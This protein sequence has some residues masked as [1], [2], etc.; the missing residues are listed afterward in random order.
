MRPLTFVTASRTVP[1]S[2][3]AAQMEREMQVVYRHNEAPE[4]TYTPDQLAALDACDAEIDR[5]VADARKLGNL[6]AQIAEILAA[7]R[8]NN[9]AVHAFEM[10]LESVVDQMDLDRPAA[11]SVA[12]EAAREEGPALKSTRDMW[13]RSA[14]DSAIDEY[15]ADSIRE[16]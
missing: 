12:Y 4:Y 11:Y 3:R 16:A 7:G 10:T 5:I 2:H 14:L 15:R 13:R 8:S 9:D 1:S 6:V